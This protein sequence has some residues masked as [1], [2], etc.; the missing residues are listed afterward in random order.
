MQTLLVK[1][2][3]RWQGIFPGEFDGPRDRSLCLKILPDGGR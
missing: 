3:R 1:T 2:N